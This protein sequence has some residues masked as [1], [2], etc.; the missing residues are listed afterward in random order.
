MKPPADGW[1]REEREALEGLQQEI[2]AARV[3][4]AGDPPVDLLRAARAGALPEDLQ[5]ATERRLAT[6]PWSRALVEGLDE[7]ESTLDRQAEDRLLSRIRGAAAT[8]G[9]ASRGSWWP[10]AFATAAAAVLV[11]AMWW[12]RS[13]FDVPGA[14]PPPRSA[15][16]GTTATPASPRV[17][18]PL[19]APEVMLSLSALTWRGEGG[20]KRLLADLKVPLDA[21]RAGDYARADREFT[22]LEPRYPRAVEVFFYGGVARLFVNDPERAAAALTRAASLA[23]DTF[24]PS[25]AWYRAIAEHRAG[26]VTQARA[27]LDALCRGGSRYAPQACN[28]IQQIDAATKAPAP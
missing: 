7:T 27:R 24:A 5:A 20:E 18:L 11:A 17:E 12:W 26:R 28:A 6:D 15:Q 3:R 10:F 13:G 16:G 8:A 22:V 4:H 19:A 9:A 23:D 21:F 14:P 25:V 1:D 2:E